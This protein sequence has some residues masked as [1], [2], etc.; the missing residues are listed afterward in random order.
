MIIGGVTQRQSSGPLNRKSRYRN[1]PPLPNFNVMIKGKEQNIISVLTNKEIIPKN[2]LFQITEEMLLYYMKY[3]QII[4]G[5]SERGIGRKNNKRFARKIAGLNLLKENFSRGAKFKDMMSGLVYVIENPS[6]PEHY[7]IGMTI[8][9][10]S[11]LESYQ[12]YDPYRKFKIVKYD[13]VIDRNVK[14]KSI[15]NHYDIFKENGEW[16]KKDNALEVFSKIC[17]FIE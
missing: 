10:I 12:T 2:S 14:E 5:K 4:F 9:L 7:K 16:I 17:N 15:L 11:R 1:S 8:D 3:Y 6:F 13:F